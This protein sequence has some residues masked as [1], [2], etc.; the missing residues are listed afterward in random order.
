[1]EQ[2]ALRLERAVRLYAIVVTVYL[3]LALT[4]AERLPPV[5]LLGQFRAWVLL[6][7]SLPLVFAF[8]LR[9]RWCAAGLVLALA[10]GLVQ[11]HRPLGQ[12]LGIVETLQAEAKP[13]DLRI[14]SWNL[15]LG[16]ASNEEALKHLER[17][18]AEVVALQEIVNDQQAFL[19][20]HASTV[21]PHQ[22]FF[23]EGRSSLGLLSKHEL[24]DVEWN[25]PKSGKPW[26]TAKIYVDG[27]GIRIVNIHVSA[28]ISI[29]GPWWDD[30][31]VL[32]SIAQT[33]SPGEPSILLGDFNG[34]ESS[35]EYALLEDASWRNAFDAAGHGFGFTFPVFLKY[36]GLPIPP[37]VRIDHIWI[38]GAVEARSFRVG[39]AA[40]SDHLPIVADLVLGAAD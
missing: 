8:S 3:V 21:F 20:E 6:G 40:G 35:G 32:E 9:R 23:G 15:G 30:H 33:H 38:K 25:E 26:L 2:R 28:L 17:T 11:Y 34:T 12:T 4:T 27:T 29:F 1:M 31:A 10:V 7:A 22:V 18:L 14:E 39:P 19:R 37:A 36:R 24:R 16:R 13:P 5:L